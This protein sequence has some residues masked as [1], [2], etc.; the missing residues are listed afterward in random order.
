MFYV[1][2]PVSALYYT[3]SNH[4]KIAIAESVRLGRVPNISIMSETTHR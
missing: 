4:F 2:L 3:N 1:S